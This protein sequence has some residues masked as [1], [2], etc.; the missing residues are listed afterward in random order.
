MSTT[1]PDRTTTLG[2]TGRSPRRRR[3]GGAARLSPGPSGLG[4]ARTAVVVGLLFAAVSLYWGLGGTWLLDT[5]GGSLE[6]RGQAGNTSVMLA[7]WA[8]VAVKIIAAVLP[9]VLRRVTSPAGNRRA[10]ALVWA[11]A[12]ALTIY[13][14][15]LTTVDLLVQADFIHAPANA[16]HR[17][18]AWHA[19]LWDPWFLLWGLLVAAAL[20]RSRDHRSCTPTHG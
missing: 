2:H 13:G 10:R 4:A 16:D 8:A 6:R 20:L 7:V 9:L 19:Y 15:V 17:A 18:L 1:P 12:A 5:V 11:E 14:L 3:A